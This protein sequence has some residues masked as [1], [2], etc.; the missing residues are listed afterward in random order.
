MSQEFYSSNYNMGQSGGDQWGQQGW[1][2]SG[3]NSPQQ[4]YVQP[5]PAAAAATPQQYNNQNQYHAYNE[6]QGG[7]QQQGF[8]TTP[9]SNYNTPPSYTT[10][11]PANQSNQGFYNSGNSFYDPNTNMGSMG[12]APAQGTSDTFEEE[13]PLMEEL[14]IDLPQI[15]QTTLTVLDPSRP[16]AT[17]LMDDPDLSG[18]LIFCLAFG[19]LLLLSGKIHFGY[20]YGVALVGAVAM[21]TLLNLMSVNGVSAS[22]T[23]SVLGYCM[24]PMCVLAAV[25]ALLSLKGLLGVVL[26]GVTVSWAAFASSKL[27]ASVLAMYDQQPLVAYPCAIMYGI[28]AVLTVF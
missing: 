24:L 20:I 6:Q 7:G 12:P 14:G 21:Y 27:F 1:D 3:Y 28:F 25:S 22:V 18:P 23:V 9:D 19:S 8:Y 10:T 26:C 15:Y 2:N 4:Q 5:Q 16:A 11:P 17:N 13:P